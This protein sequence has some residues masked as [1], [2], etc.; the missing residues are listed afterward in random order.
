[1]TPHLTTF[2]FNDIAGKPFDA[3]SLQ[4]KVVLVVNTAS[5]CGLTPQYE[6]LEKLY[7]THQAKGLVILGFPCNQ[8]LGQEPG[9]EAEIAQ[10]CQLNYQVSFPMMQKI[11]VNGGDAHPLF[12]WLTQQAPGLLGIKAVKWNFTKFL[13]AKDGSSV[14]RFAPQTEPA[15]MEADIQKALAA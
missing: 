12:Q 8:F 6:G 15:D 10:F 2:T 4:G 5:G 9:T 7:K 11:D 13:V 14:K 1:M 3:A